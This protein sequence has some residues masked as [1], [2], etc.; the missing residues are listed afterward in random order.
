MRH[1]GFTL[2]L[3]LVYFCPIAPCAELPES[4]YEDSTFTE[5]D[6]LM[7]TIMSDNDIT[8]GALG[9]MK[10]GYIVYMRGFGYRDSSLTEVLQEDDLF[11]IASVTKPITAAAIRTLIEAGSIALDDYVFDLGQ[12][13]G[14]IL[15]H[16]PYPS[17]GDSRLADITIEQLLNHGGGWD[18]YIAGDLTYMEVNIASEMGVS[19]P[20]GRDNVLRYILGQPLQ[21]APGTSYAYSNIGFLVLGLIVEEVSGQDYITYVRENVFDDTGAEVEIG[22]TF[23]QDR[24]SREP[25][26]DGTY[27]ATNVFDPTGPLVYWPEGGWHHEARVGQGALVTNTKTLLRYL[28]TY[29]IAGSNIGLPRASNSGNWNH[30]GSLNGTTSLAR[31]RSTGINYAVVFNKRTST[32]PSYSTQMRT[33]MDDLIINETV[34]FPTTLLS[35]LSD[36]STPET[37]GSEPLTISFTDLSNGGH[38]FVD[39]WAW[40]FGDPASGDNESTT[41]NP[42]HTYKVPGTYTVSLSVM[43]ANGTDIE[44]KTGLIVVV[45]DVSAEALELRDDFLQYD[46][47]DDLYLTFSESGILQWEFNLLDINEDNYVSF[48]ELMIETVGSVRQVSPVYVDFEYQGTELGTLN[49]PFNTLY[50]GKAFTM[51]GGAIYIQ[52][53]DSSEMPNLKR[54]MLLIN[55]HPELG[56]V[57][58]GI[59][60]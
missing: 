20:P 26:Y 50:E 32:S 51:S 5:F 9:V 17:L 44:I 48:D 2:F 56:K 31:Q 22:R 38:I 27:G 6:S 53:S 46:R 45:G 58:I 35:P 40:D 41:R 13:E 25:Y 43:N 8:A 52:P 14:G 11:R 42:S 23:P 4:G 57:V 3:L 12:T 39:E 19:N 34:T 49:E 18:L 30:T 15:T 37:S 55:A 28:N 54:H 33:A 16:S 47:N 10:D 21:S 29:Y 59:A 1:L 60:E 36:F 24:N 7:Q